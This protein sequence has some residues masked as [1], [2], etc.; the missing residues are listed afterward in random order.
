MSVETLVR[1]VHSQHLN[2]HPTDLVP[3]D[4]IK[5]Q[6]WA[7][8]NGVCFDC[9]TADPNAPPDSLETAGHWAFGTVMR[10]CK[11]DCPAYGN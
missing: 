7:M 8:P 6:T 9:C 4:R 5:C 10:G 3:K 2:K 1:C 11:K